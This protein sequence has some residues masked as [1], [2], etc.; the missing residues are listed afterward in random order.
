MRTMA[1]ISTVALAVLLEDKDIA[2][3]LTDRAV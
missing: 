3:K 2:D 1:L